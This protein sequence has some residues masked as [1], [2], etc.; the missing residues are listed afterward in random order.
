[1]HCGETQLE[2]HSRKAGSRQRGREKREDWVGNAVRNLGVPLRR[3][4]EVTYE[5]AS[6]KTVGIPYASEA[7]QRTY[8]WFLG[9]PDVQPHYVVLLCETT[10]GELFHFVLDHACV[11]NIWGSLSRDADHHVKFHVKRS[12]ANWELKLKDGPLL[13]L[14]EYCL[15]GAASILR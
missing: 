1:M 3:L 6:R 2:K 8:P 11:S 15:P 12:G 13:Q 4:G 14:N 7:P 10:A 9:L 5:T